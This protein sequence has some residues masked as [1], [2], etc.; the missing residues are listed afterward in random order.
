MAPLTGE[1]LG[2]KVGRETS[3]FEERQLRLSAKRHH[4]ASIQM[5]QFSS[6]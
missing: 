1:K 2:A 4:R 3:G 5:A 6:V